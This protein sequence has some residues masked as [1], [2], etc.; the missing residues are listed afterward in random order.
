MFTPFVA[1]W[2]E[3]PF[4]VPHPVV[5][6]L[7]AEWSA[8]YQGSL[9]LKPC[10]TSFQKPGYVKYPSDFTWCVLS[11]VSLHHRVQN[12]SGARPASYT[13]CTRGS[14]PG[15]KAAGTWSWP[16][17]SSAE[18]EEWV[19]LYAF[20]V[21]CSAKAQ[22]Q[23]YLLPLPLPLHLPLLCCNVSSPSKDGGTLDL[24]NVGV[25]PHHCTA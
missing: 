6:Y 15:D 18:V 17:P 16:L 7:V 19:E 21:W 4:M 9:V 14:F 8:S 23:L 22:G 11:P 2:Y 12:G 5:D 20:M 13:M 25:L 1:L 24:W 10:C 3:I